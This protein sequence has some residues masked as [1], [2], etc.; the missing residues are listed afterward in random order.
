MPAITFKISDSQKYDMLFNLLNPAYCEEGGWMIS[1][2]IG[3]I[4]DDYALIYNLEEGQYE[5]AYYTKDDETDSLT[6]NKRK[7]CYILDVSEEEYTALKALRAM[8]GETYEKVDEVFSTKNEQI[9]EYEA[10]IEE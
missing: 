5:R 3:D 9:S 1:A 8:N 6:I 2:V 7:K 4:Y 10:K